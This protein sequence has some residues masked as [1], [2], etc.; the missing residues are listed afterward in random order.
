MTT[1]QISPDAIRLESRTFRV[2][3][4]LDSLPLLHSLREVGQLNPVLLLE[5]PSGPEIVC[6]FRRVHAMKELGKTE[7]LARILRRQDCAEA[8][9]FLIALWD[10]LSHRQFSPLERAGALFK[11][12]H[13]CG[14][15]D[16]RLIKTFLP[17]LGLAP[18][19]NV[20]KSHL[21]LNELCP[22]LRRCLAEGKLTQSSSEF[23][24]AMPVQLQ[25]DVAAVMDAIR[26]SA[27]LQKKGLQ[28]LEELCSLPDGE[29]PSPLKSPQVAA[30]LEDA[31]LSPFQ[32]GEKVYEI[33]YRFRSPRL[34][35]AQGRFLANRKK[36]ALPGSIQIKPHPFFEE[37]G[38]SVEFR[39]SSV[40]HFRQL[41]S[42]LNVAAQSPDTE[43]LF[44]LDC[45]QADEDPNDSG[46]Q[47]PDS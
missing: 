28:L 8:Q 39:A 21:L 41:A 43:R 15:P 34:S 12:K 47:I 36:L 9:A 27:S 29:S 33:L 37:Q 13:M 40:E 19:K 26:W 31:G 32:K 25:A 1:I 35:R 23:L 24:A 2:S 46:F 45:D 20:L 6:G 5:S 3:E 4:D 17:A 11:L 16:E 22:G 10:N 38:L 7:V 14:L 44:D 18:N 30:V 42:A